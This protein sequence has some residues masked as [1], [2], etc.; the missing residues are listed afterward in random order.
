MFISSFYSKSLI[1]VPV[2][3][4]SLLVPYMFFFISLCIAF[5]SSFILQPY[6]VISVSILMTSV[7]KHAYDRLAI[8]SLLSSNFGALI[9][10][11]GPYIFLSWHACYVVRGRS[12]GIHQGGATQVALLSH[13]VWGRGQRGNNDTCLLSSHRLSVT[14][15]ATHKQI[16]PFWC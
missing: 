4:P 1:G 7:L 13:C 16:G 14:F 15:P 3:F 12:L 2:S 8:F 6:S 11:F 10:S 9:C 5:T